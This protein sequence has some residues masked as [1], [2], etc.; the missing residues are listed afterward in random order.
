[1]KNIGIA[2]DRESYAAECQVLHCVVD[3][4]QRVLTS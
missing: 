2:Y 1:M 4:Y 3:Y